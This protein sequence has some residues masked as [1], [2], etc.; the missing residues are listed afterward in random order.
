MPL[1]GTVLA[2]CVLLQLLHSLVSGRGRAGT[3][4]GALVEA[5]VGLALALAMRLV[6]APVLPLFRY[7]F[8]CVTVRK[9]KPPL[10]LLIGVNCT[11]FRSFRRYFVLRLF[12]LTFSKFCAFRGLPARVRIVW[13]MI[14]R[15]LKVDATGS[16]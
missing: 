1:L 4:S 12:K 16:P 3:R 2:D 15:E 10:A 8:A 7:S 5:L 13:H 6:K 14:L 11:F 9:P